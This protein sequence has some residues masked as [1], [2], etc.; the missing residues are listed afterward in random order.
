M[1]LFMVQLLDL[2]YAAI[3]NIGYLNYGD[4]ETAWTLSIVKVR[5]IPLTYAFRLWC[6]NGMAIE[7][8]SF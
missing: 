7:F 2:G 4:L 8:K 1:L 5:Y 6:F 3:E